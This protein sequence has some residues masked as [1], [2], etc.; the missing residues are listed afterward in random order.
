VRDVAGLLRSID[1]IGSAAARRAGRDPGRWIAAA[2]RAAVRGY[3]GTAPAAPDPALLDALEL[4]KECGELVYARRV[5]PEWAYAP[6]RGLE[7]LLRRTTE[8]EG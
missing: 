3:A 4:A 6:R 5:L 2:T 1:H 7:R 8:G